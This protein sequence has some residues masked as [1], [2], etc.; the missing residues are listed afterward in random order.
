MSSLGIIAVE[1]DQMCEMCGII[2]ECR[3]YGINDEQICFE[4]AMK[5]KETTTRKMNAYIFGNKE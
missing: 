2:S 3:P 5:D 4:C 1:P